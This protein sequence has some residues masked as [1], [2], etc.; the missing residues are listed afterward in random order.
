LFAVS[1]A[2]S[3]SLIV[4]TDEVDSGCGPG[5]KF[6]SGTCVDVGDPSYG[7]LQN[8]CEP[9]RRDNGVPRCEANDC[10]YDTCLY[11]WGCFDCREQILSN[12]AHCGGCNARCP[13][14][15]STCSLGECIPPGGA[16]AG[17]EAGG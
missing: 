9:C 16:G 8:G 3:C 7:C 10:E 15:G 6:C 14:A 11:G 17:G 2:L 1:A 5:K 12:P 13:I 4:D